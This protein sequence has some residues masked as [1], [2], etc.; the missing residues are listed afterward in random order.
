MEL[1]PDYNPFINQTNNNIPVTK[2][3]VKPEEIKIEKSDQPAVKKDDS[4]LKDLAQGSAQ[5]YIDL[6]LDDD[7]IF[8]DEDEKIANKF[9]FDSVKSLQSS[10]GATADG[11][12]GTDTLTKLKDSLVKK[13][14]E[15]EKELIKEIPAQ[16]GV[17]SLAEAQKKIG[18]MPD[19]KLGPETINKIDSLLDSDN[20]ISNIVN[21]K[22]KSQQFTA[23]I[24]LMQVNLQMTDEVLKLLN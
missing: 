23:M 5:T 13:S 21:T 9:G 17:S 2:T 11:I 15:L 10:V 1:G 7:D 12:L 19:G 8:S 14:A 16:L 22:L 24:K 3:Q 4:D 6:G 20:L 18:V